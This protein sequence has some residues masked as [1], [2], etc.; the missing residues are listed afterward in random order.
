[1]NC[2]NNTKKKDEFQKYVKRCQTLEYRGTKEPFGAKEKLYI[3]SV[4]ATQ[5]YIFFNKL[6]GWGLGKYTLRGICCD[7]H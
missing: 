2:L 7:E 4:V 1:M 6:C 5:G 3:P